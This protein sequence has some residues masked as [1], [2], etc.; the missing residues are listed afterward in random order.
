MELSGL[1]VKPLENNKKNKKV[2]SI[3][4]YIYIREKGSKGLFK[5]VF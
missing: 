2:K 4:I 5:K 3:K 1:I